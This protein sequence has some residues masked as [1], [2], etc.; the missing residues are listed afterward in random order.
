MYYTQCIGS[1]NYAPDGSGSTIQSTNGIP[2]YNE[3]IWLLRTTLDWDTFPMTFPLRPKVFVRRYCPDIACCDIHA[4]RTLFDCT[5]MND[6]L[7][8]PSTPKVRES[9]S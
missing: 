3:R 2:S 5:E 6:I 8:Q 1:R 9:V 7:C 4:D